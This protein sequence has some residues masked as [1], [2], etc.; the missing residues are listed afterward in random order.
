M[1]DTAEINDFEKSFSEKY[2]DDVLSLEGVMFSFAG[3]DSECISI[4]C[5]NPEKNI[6]GL[7]VFGKE[8]L[9]IYIPYSESQMTAMCRAA[10][11]KSKKEEDQ[12]ICL[13]D[14]SKLKID[15]FEEKKG[16][17]SLFQEKKLSVTFLYG[18]RLQRIFI[19]PHKN[20]T[21]VFEKI[22]KYCY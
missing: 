9:H 15:D 18:D 16:L 19:R 8:K 5:D 10:S 20:I 11:G 12:Y 14:F 22:K 1:T 2:N 7:L 13:S 17:F 4:R 3:T 6:F 21:S